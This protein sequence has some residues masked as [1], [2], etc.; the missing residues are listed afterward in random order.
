MILSN[1]NNFI[2]NHLDLF[3]QYVKDGVLPMDTTNDGI[4]LRP[5]AYDAWY[6]LIIKSNA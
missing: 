3:S 4:H 1:A 2:L 5:D 6:N